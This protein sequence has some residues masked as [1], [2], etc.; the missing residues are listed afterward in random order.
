MDERRRVSVVRRS[1]RRLLGVVALL[2]GVVGIVAVPAVSSAS[3]ASSTYVIGNIGTYSGPVS[4]DYG[5]DRQVLTAWQDATNAAGGING[6]HVKVIALDDQG[7]PTVALQDAQELVQQDH[8]LAV[9]DD[10]SNGGTSYGSYLE[11]AGV[12]L[13]GATSNP[14]A[15]TDTLFFPVGAS[16]LGE[17]YGEAASAKLV[18]ASKIAFIYCAESA[19]C[20]QVVP[21]IKTDAAANGATVSYVSAAPETAPSYTAYCLS[22]KQSGATA[23]LTALASPAVINIAEGCAQQGY[24]PTFLVGGAPVGPAFSNTSALNGSIAVEGVFPWVQD[25]TPATKAFHAALTKYEP[26]VAKSSTYNATT[27]YSWAGAELFAAGAAKMTGDSPKA[28]ATAMYTLKNVTLGGLISP[29]S[30]SSTKQTNPDCYTQMKQVNDKYTV[31]NNGKFT[32]PPA[33]S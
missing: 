12:P 28:L 30:F 9:V 7:N 22:A 25:S 32:C 21:L 27:A 26:G 3:A 19:V 5:S 10:N 24:K 11:T 6:H 17:I 2:S 29:E 16:T 8:V 18:H 4:G 14:P 23:I 31:L 1:G 13:I 20:G 15:P 33:S